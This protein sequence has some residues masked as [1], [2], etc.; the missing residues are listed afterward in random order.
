[1]LLSVSCFS[2]AGH[3]LVYEKTACFFLY[4]V[5]VSK[6]SALIKLKKRNK[7]AKHNHQQALIIYFRKLASTQCTL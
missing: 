7:E 1:M 4:I 6:S 5:L 2:N 3:Y